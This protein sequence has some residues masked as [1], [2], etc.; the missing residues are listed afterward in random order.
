MIIAY[1]FKSILALFTNAATCY[2]GGKPSVPHHL[3]KITLQDKLALIGPV[4]K[5]RETACLPLSAIRGYKLTR[6]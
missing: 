2:V 6:C 1:A 5:H 3:R 4:G